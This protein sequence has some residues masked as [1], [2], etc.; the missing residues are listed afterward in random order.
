MSWEFSWKM[1]LVP[2]M[3]NVRLAI[4]EVLYVA[5]LKF[6]HLNGAKLLISANGV[7]INEDIDSMEVMDIF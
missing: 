4:L 2:R 5:C 3:L 7:L 1:Q 6:G